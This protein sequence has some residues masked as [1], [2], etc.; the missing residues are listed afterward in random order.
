MTLF[1]LAATAISALS[2]P[3]PYTGE[4]DSWGEFS[5]YSVYQGGAL[6]VRLGTLY[7][8]V[9]GQ[10]VYWAKGVGVVEGG[11][12][13]SLKCPALKL[14][15]ESIERIPIPKPALSEIY[16]IESDAT[17]YSVTVPYHGTNLSK[18]TITAGRGPVADWVENALKKLE[19][20]WSSN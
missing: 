4:H 5:R 10:Q 12:T 9:P 11:A 7:R 13:D 20:C 17:L 2:Q 19:S 1:F 15:V 6:T 14:V 16:V 3:A 18:L 8:K